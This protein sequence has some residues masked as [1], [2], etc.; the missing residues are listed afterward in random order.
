MLSGFIGAYKRFDLGRLH[1]PIMFSIGK[2][3]KFTPTIRWHRGTKKPATPFRGMAGT[4]PGND[5][6][7][8]G[9]SPY[10]HWRGDVSLPGSEWSRVVPLCYGHQNLGLG[11]M[12]EPKLPETSIAF[13]ITKSKSLTT[14]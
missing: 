14:V 13:T 1:V 5:L 3:V 7:S 2:A 4:S 10:Y 9:L 12:T 8:Q 11:Q 6:L